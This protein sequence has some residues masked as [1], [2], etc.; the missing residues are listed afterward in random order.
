MNNNLA[1]KKLLVEEIKGKLQSAKTVVFID[2]S[3]LN[4][5]EADQLRKDFRNSKAEYKVYKNRLLLKALT[6]LGISGVDAH[7]NGNTS[8]AFGYE[9]EISAARITADS[10]KN[11]KKMAIKF[12]LFNG[13]VVSNKVIE[14]LAGLPS[15]QVLV[16]QLLSV[17]NG[18]VTGLAR[19]LTAINENRA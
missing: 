16:A 9:D 17:L 7:L 5:A 10:I 13:G 14:S 18:P 2:Y 1:N 19:A 4:V 8:V 11:I 3:G 15:K 6:E 12:G